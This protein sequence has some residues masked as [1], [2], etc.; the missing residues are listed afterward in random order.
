MHHVALVGER[1]TLTV[2]LL[3]ENCV[4]AVAQLLLAAGA[5]LDVTDYEGKAPLDLAIEGEHAEIANLFAQAGAEPR[6]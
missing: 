6:V 3:E 2:E 5:R 1:D 4:A